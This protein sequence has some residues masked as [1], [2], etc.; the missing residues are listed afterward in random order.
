M[1][2]ELGIVSP[3]PFFLEKGGGGGGCVNIGGFLWETKK[4][5]RKKNGNILLVLWK[6][7]NIGHIEGIKKI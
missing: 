3:P 5:Q 6:F 1:K 4:N 7:A 2:T